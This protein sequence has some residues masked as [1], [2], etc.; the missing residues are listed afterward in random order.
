[1]TWNGELEKK[2]L[3]KKMSIECYM[4]S[5]TLEQLTTLLCVGIFFLFID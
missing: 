4:T 3:Q 2:I 5:N 1:M